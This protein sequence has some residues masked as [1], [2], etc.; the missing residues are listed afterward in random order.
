MSV[1]PKIA[2][3]VG[4]IAVSTASI[5]VRLSSSPAL[6]IAAYRMLFA[7]VLMGLLSINNLKNIKILSK[8]EIFILIIL[9][10]VALGA[11]FGAW[12]MSLFYTT[13]A[14]STILTDSSPIFVVIISYVLFKEQTKLRE[15]LGIIISL[16]G[17]VIIISGS[18]AI[19]DMNNLYGD[20]L[21][22]L[23][24]FFLSIYLVVGRK[25]RR[26]VDLVSYT[27]T[28]YGIASITLFII[29]LFLMNNV[30]VSSLHEMLI[31]L[32]L[33]L[34]PSGLGHNSYNYALKYL[35]A[36]IVSVSILGEPVGASVLAI[37]IFNEI[38]T[39]STVIGGI[40]VV[41]GIIITTLYREQQ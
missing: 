24:A 21:A 37:I 3:F 10:G 6:V 11:H 27:F 8:K 17:A 2:L 1:N 4:I 32:A 34:I 41:L 9:S 16:I 15:L 7:S 29:A 33:A 28:V 18:V 38:P 20:L 14:A 30:M 5:F 36:S 25:L 12:T 26:K 23:S 19:K 39:I 13:I 31:F 22:L 40:I 35:K